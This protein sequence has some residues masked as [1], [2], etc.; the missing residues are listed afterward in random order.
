MIAE[1]IYPVRLTSDLAEA[2]R[3]EVSGHEHPGKAEQDQEVELH[4]P[5]SGENWINVALTIHKDAAR[6]RAARS[7]CRAA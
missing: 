4:E 1:T 7:P 2:G 5:N 6:R 3:Q